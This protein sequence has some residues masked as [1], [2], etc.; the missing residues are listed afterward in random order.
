MAAGYSGDD[1]V[2]LENQLP[3]MFELGFAF[4]AWSTPEAVLRKAG[5]DPAVA[6]ADAKFNG[7]RA[8]GLSRRQI[9]AL[10]L[11]ICGTQTVEG[12]PHL[13]EKHLAVFDCA[14]RCGNLGTRFIAPEGHIRMMAAAQPFISGAISAR[15]E[16][17]EPSHSRLGAIRPLDS[18]PR[19]RASSDGSAVRSASAMRR[20]TSRFFT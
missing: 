14:N 2:A 7:L 16:P 1:L 20:R 4:S 18:K 10:N 9:D 8:L 6:K 15:H 17:A 11:R 19:M 13:K 5:R 12:A 3:M